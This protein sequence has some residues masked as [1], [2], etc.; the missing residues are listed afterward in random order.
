MAKAKERTIEDLVNETY[1]DPA[2]REWVMNVI[3]RENASMEARRKASAEMGEDA[4][5]PPSNVERILR[6]ELKL[7]HPVDV[8]ANMRKERWAQLMKQFEEE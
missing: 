4:Q 6:G 8:R 7:P 2:Q 1:P 5:L 3:K